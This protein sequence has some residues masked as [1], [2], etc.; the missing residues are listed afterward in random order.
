MNVSSQNSQQL[1]DGNN[2]QI[3]GILVWCQEGILEAER[4]FLEILSVLIG[5]WNWYDKGCQ[6]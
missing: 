5:L 1:K 4:N 3:K 6:V 2:S